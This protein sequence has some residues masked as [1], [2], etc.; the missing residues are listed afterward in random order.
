MKRLQ[1]SN[2]RSVWIIFII[3]LGC[4]FLFILWLRAASLTL[5]LGSS[6]IIN[7]DKTRF[8]RPYTYQVGI[9]SPE[10]ITFE[11]IDTTSYKISFHETEKNP[12]TDFVVISSERNTRYPP[13]ECRYFANGS[14]EVYISLVDFGKYYLDTVVSKKYKVISTPELLKE[15]TLKTPSPINDKYLDLLHQRSEWIDSIW[16]RPYRMDVY[17]SGISIEVRDSLNKIH[18][19]KIVRKWN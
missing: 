18:S 7:F 3:L 4:V 17:N 12:G 13:I 10:Y 8:H 1:L 5:S 6:L 2:N 9:G 11:R 14:K 16:K 15:D 19:P